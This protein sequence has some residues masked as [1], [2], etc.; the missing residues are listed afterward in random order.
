M[1]KSRVKTRANKKMGKIEEAVD[2]RNYYGFNDPT[3]YIA[4]LNIRNEERA[5]Y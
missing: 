1:P 3:P 4:V 2:K 5:K